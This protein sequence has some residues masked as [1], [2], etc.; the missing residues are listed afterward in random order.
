MYKKFQDTINKKYK[1]TQKQMNEVIGALNLHETE[2]ITNREI[3]EL[4][5]KKRKY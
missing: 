3:S 1:K 4:K 2:N 5:I